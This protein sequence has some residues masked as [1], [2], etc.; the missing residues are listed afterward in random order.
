MDKIRATA[1]AGL[2]RGLRQPGVVVRK[3]KK[4]KPRQLSAEELAKLRR[5]LASEA[6]Y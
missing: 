4:R 1:Y 5:V 2:R 3:K 6:L